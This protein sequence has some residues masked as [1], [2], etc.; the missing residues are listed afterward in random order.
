[1]PL[2]DGLFLKQ[3]CGKVFFTFIHYI[4]HR[5]FPPKVSEGLGLFKDG[6]N[7]V[8][9]WKAKGSTWQGFGFLPLPRAPYRH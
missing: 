8:T 4:H 7:N 1:M 2:M 3:R 6:N 5:N 9:S